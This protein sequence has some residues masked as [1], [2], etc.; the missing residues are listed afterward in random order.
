MLILTTGAVSIESLEAARILRSYGI[1]VSVYSIPIL[2][3]LTFN[4]Q[5]I[6]QFENILVVEE[7]SVSGGL[8]SIVSEQIA[9]RQLQVKLVK[10]ALPVEV[11]HEL[12]SQKY[13][14]KYF[15]IDSIGIAN[16]VVKMLGN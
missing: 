2:K 1:Q 3:P 14:R 5:L 8:G 10:L 15:G 11:H 12:G 4:R 16:K 7:H 6:E 9:L 13:L